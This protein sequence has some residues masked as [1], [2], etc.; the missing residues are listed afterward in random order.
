MSRRLQDNLMAAAFL[1]VF[2]GVIVMSLDFGPRARMI[3]L[4]L[5]IFGLVLTVIQIVW[6]NTRST[7]ELHMEL[8]QVDAPPIVQAAAE[9]V[10][11]KTPRKGSEW[12]RE[13]AALAMI[14]ILLVLVLA[15]GPVPAVFVFTW[16]YFLLSRH[17]SWA[18]GLIYTAIF[19]GTIYWLFFVALE[20][21]PYHG[22]LE[23]LVERLK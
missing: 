21:Q 10:P 20:I 11:P 9:E 18:R 5:A 7:D 6:Q 16:G 3:P 19:T 12:R 8:I 1:A 2:I 13:V 22:L 23:P 17:Y 4:P 15:L 14:G